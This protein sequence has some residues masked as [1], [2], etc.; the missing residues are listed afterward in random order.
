MTDVNE[1]DWI[2]DLET[3]KDIFCACFVHVS[4][5]AEYVYEVSDRV[6]HGPDFIGFLYYLR[7]IDARAFG[8]NNINF[9]WPVCD[10]LIQV[11]STQGFIE[12]IDAHEKANTI[13]FGNNSYEHVIWERDRL[14]TQGD[15]FKIHHFDNVARATSLKKL[16]INMR[17]EK[18]CRSTL[19]T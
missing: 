6:N 4:T 13:I 14:V 11:F 16:E 18:G 1:R 5:G 3:Y 17:S 15:L 9:D 10:H 7:D 2:Y 12:A 19:P 8:F